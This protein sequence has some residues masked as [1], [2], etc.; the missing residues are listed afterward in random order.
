MNTGEEIAPDHSDE[1]DEDMESE[2][3]DRSPFRK[4]A[5]RS[6]GHEAEEET[7][8]TPHRAEPRR[9]H[10]FDTALNPR[11]DRTDFGKPFSGRPHVPPHLLEHVCGLGA[12]A[13]ELLGRPGEGVFVCERCG[14]E[15]EET[16]EGEAWVGGVSGD[17]I[18]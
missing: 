12:G 16:S 4:R 7:P 8:P 1:E 5:R 11:V 3:R 2:Y 15:G 6:G 10:P 9:T 14:H 13:D 18:R 17:R